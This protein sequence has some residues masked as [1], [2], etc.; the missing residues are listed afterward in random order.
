VKVLVEFTAAKDESMISKLLF[1]LGPQFGELILGFV[2]P[3]LGV[4]VS[5]STTP[6]K[7][8]S[9]ENNNANFFI[10]KLLLR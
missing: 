1:N 8:S 6:Q 10:F 5:A 3:V 4:T 2:I 9:E 7:R